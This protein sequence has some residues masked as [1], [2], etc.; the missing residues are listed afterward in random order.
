MRA[1]L[2]VC[3]TVLMAPVLL[4]IGIALGPAILGILFVA[5][6]AIVVVSIWALFSDQAHDQRLPPAHR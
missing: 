6:I 3:A 5:V 4:L 1:F 2:A